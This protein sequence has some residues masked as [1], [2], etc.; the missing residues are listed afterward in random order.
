[1]GISIFFFNFAAHP[2]KKCLLLV[3]F[4]PRK[5]KGRNIFIFVLEYVRTLLSRIIISCGNADS[6]NY[7]CAHGKRNKK[8]KFGKT[9]ARKEIFLLLLLLPCVMIS[10]TCKNEIKNKCSWGRLDF[11]TF[12]LFW[13]E[14]PTEFSFSLQYILA[15]AAYHACT[16][17]KEWKLASA[18]AKIQRCLIIASVR[19]GPRPSESRI[20]CH[21]MYVWWAHCTKL[22]R[23]EIKRCDGM[24][25]ETRGSH[26]GGLNTIFFILD[27]F[28][29]FH[30]ATLTTRIIFFDTLCKKY[31]KNTPA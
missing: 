24:S 4:V 21:T 23:G 22:L 16:Q 11:F 8:W 5:K 19:A 9:E 14:N 28:L 31:G 29:L 12:S 18:L 20:S 27:G 10:F 15:F 25:M 26:T 17:E 1:M 3:R 7:F 13:V 6:R 2:R 30:V